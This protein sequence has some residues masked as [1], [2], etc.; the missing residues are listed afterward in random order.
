MTEDQNEAGSPCCAA[1]RGTDSAEANETRR[2]SGGTSPEEADTGRMVEI[3][4]GSFLMGT[5]DEGFPAD[6]E[7]LVREVTVDSFYI[8]RYHVTNA[9]FVQFVRD[10][11]Y[12]TDAERFGWSFVFQDFISPDDEGYVMDTVPDAPWWCAVKRAT[13]VQPEGPSSSIEDR[14][15]HP[16]VHVSWCDARA[17]CEW[18]NKRLPT[19]TEWEFAARG[20]LEQKTF[21]WGDEL[22]S[23]GEHRCNIWQG[24]FP[25]E[26]TKEDG[27]LGTAPVTEYEPNGYGLY[28]VAGNVWEW[29]GDRFSATHHRDGPR[30]NPTGPP[31]G[32]ERVM[33]GGSY[34]CHESY[35]NRYRVA[36]RSKNTPESS[37]G[38]IGFRC[39]VDVA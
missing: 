18:A 17:Y 19:E 25:D 12:T 13:W 28:N 26:N 35:C 14:L 34:L 5:D 1:D 31:T 39:V 9:D 37:T 2:E 7:G 15:K 23:N 33:R 24:S 29:V 8:D 36:A 3:E 11:G 21:P 27:Y 16:V 30:D 22:V 10:T 20:G 38:N 4:S 32:D 6:G